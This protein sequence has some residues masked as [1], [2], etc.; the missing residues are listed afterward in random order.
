MASFTLA[1]I[2][3]MASQ[4][5]SRWLTPDWFEEAL[6]RVRL[7]E[8]RLL[9]NWW[10]SSGLLEAAHG[11]L[12]SRLGQQA[13]RECLLF[14]SL[15]LS[16]ALVFHLLAIVVAGRMFRPGYTA[17][18]GDRSPD[19]RISA[20]SAGRLAS[21][22]PPLVPAPLK[23][24][25]LKDLKLFRRD[26]VQW[27]QFIVFFSLL[28]L[29]FFNT[30]RL[31]FNIEYAAWVNMISFL[32]LAI[33]GLILSTF[34]TR[35]IFPLISLEGRRCWILGLLPIRRDVILW[36]KFL[37]AAGGAWIPV[38]VLA[39]TSDFML[40]VTNDLMLVHLYICALLC[41]GLSG[42]A[43]G[44]GARFA[45]FRHESPARIAAGFGGT[46]TLIV[47]TCYIVVIV[48]LAAVPCHFYSAFASAA[49]D[50]DLVFH[51]RFGPW[52]TASLA[53]SFAICAIATGVPL[54]LGLRAFRR[55]EF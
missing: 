34:T 44:L 15:L 16:N 14:L 26:S 46:L 24:L 28:T 33:I 36:G 25:I 11:N 18:H 53:A 55:I 50:A 3:S 7:T 42:I 5:E 43:V 21:A 41:L 39:F 10:L 13:L 23:L 38:S 1:V 20:R 37:F 47:S 17:L 8:Y 49:A 19:R 48:L 51:E 52:W 32:N 45:N 9:P 22:V 35:F 40:G 4:F 6:A 54:W 29:Y 12:T 30:R 31:G 2:W 27:S